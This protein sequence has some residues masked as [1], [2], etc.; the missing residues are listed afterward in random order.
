MEAFEL[1]KYGVLLLSCLQPG[2]MGLHADE[3][4]FD[5][6]LPDVVQL[7]S[8]SPIEI[9]QLLHTEYIYIYISNLRTRVID[10]LC[11]CMCVNTCLLLEGTSM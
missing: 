3:S 4:M 6:R 7:S 9:H 11:V 1:Q 5:K 10:A 2:H 8:I